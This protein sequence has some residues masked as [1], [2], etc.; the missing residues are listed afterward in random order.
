MSKFQQQ[1]G[2]VALGDEF[3]IRFP[4]YQADGTPWAPEATAAQFMAK[5][6]RD[7]PD[8]MAVVSEDLDGGITIVGSDAAVRVEQVDQAAL[9]GTTTLHWSFRVT[10]EADGPVTVAA[11]T[12]RLERFAVRN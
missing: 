2:P 4:L 8:A 11:G 10:T 1:L 12:L 6:S 5:V 9:T 3:V 7:D